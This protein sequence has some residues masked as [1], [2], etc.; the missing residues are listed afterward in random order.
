M[1]STYAG[2][3]WNRYH[4]QRYAAVMIQFTIS[5][6]A[7]RW[8]TGFED[9]RFASWRN[10]EIQQLWSSAASKMGLPLNT[11]QFHVQE[12][13]IKCSLTGNG[14]HHHCLS[15]SNCSFF[16]NWDRTE[17]IWHSMTLKCLVLN[18]FKN[19]CVEGEL[20]CTWTNSIWTFVLQLSRRT[21]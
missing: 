19:D 9:H 6:H 11:T 1:L 20:W 7:K 13:T 15:V 21:K 18:E 12:S 8:F 16:Y 5:T 4:R 2:G 10:S 17:Y 14:V 3:I